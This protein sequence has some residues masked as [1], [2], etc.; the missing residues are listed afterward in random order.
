MEVLE[1]RLVKHVV[2]YFGAMRRADIKLA[3]TEAFLQTR[4]AR[5]LATMTIHPP[6]IALR[7]VPKDAVARGMLGGVL[8]RGEYRQLVRTGRAARST[9]CALRRSC[10]A[11][12]MGR[13]STC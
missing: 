9:A 13:A 7:K 6:V 11:C 12:F 8:N 1:G 3:H 10:T 4:S 2:P 5:P